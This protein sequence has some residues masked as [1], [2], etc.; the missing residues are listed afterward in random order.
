MTKTDT[1]YNGWTNRATWAVNLWLTNDETMFSRAVDYARDSGEC[2]ST[3]NFYIEGMLHNWDHIVEDCDDFVDV[4]WAEILKT[5][6][7]PIFAAE[8]TR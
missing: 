3:F 2:D 6:F 1:K 5:T 8:P 7:A 4:N